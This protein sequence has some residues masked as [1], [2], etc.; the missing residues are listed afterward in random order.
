MLCPRCGAYAPEDEIV[1]HACGKLLEREK[2][3]EEEDLQSFYQGKHMRLRREAERQAAERARSERAADPG[4]SHSFRSPYQRAATEAPLYDDV[5]GVDPIT[6][7]SR[8]PTPLVPA[9]R[10]H[11]AIRLQ[12]QRKR[13][14]WAIVGVAV[15]LLMCGM[16]VGTYLYLDKTPGG[17]VLMARMGRD[18]N[19][20]ALWQV[21]AEFLDTG[22]LDTAI[23]YFLRA[24]EKD[25][26][27]PNV[28]GLLELGSA[29]EAAGRNEEAE[30]IYAHI[31]TDLVPSAPEAYRS[32]VRLLIA[33]DRQPEAADLL[34]LAYQ[35]TGVASFLSQRTDM[36]PSV[37][38]SSVIAGYYAEIK[39]VQLLQSQEYDVYYLLN[40][41]DN[42]ASDQLEAVLPDEGTLYTEPLKLGE[43][44]WTI[45]AVAVHEGLVSDPMTAVFQI[46]MPTPLQPDTTLAPGTYQQRQRV[47]LSPG[48]LTPEQLEKN[49]GYAASM[50]DETAMDITIYY[51]IDGS[52]PD[53]DSPIYTGEKILLPGGRVTLRAVAVNGYGK[54]GNVKEVGY[55]IEA[56]PWPKSVYAS[57]DGIADWKLGTT[58]RDV[59]FQR[60]GADAPSESTT[61]PHFAGECLRYQFSWG[62]ATFTRGKAGWVL[63]MVTLTNTEISGPRKTAVGMTESEVTAVFKDYGQVESPS[64]NRGLYD[65]LES[66]DR[67]KIYKQADGTKIIRYRTDT[68]EGYVWQLDYLVNQDG[69][70]TSIEWQ[71]EP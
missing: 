17:Q 23:D 56:K 50:K 27:S 36:L 4:A 71:Y 69:I 40:E 46:Y 52:M 45:K 1:C 7:T 26:D 62:T 38:Q 32:Q 42:P 58:T 37:P 18:A 14:N 54:A 8:V 55:K 43:G 19:A 5:G 16:A 48:S 29:Y 20:A 21:G 49:P 12:N 61:L 65:D 70:V 3:A 60:Y 30:A 44:E 66:S 51:T 34:K 24:Q 31:Y 6:S 13:V 2:D 35:N 39:T 59:F 25:G 53:A 63:A 11:R 41:L 10:S 67:G 47:G 57:S 68:A 9:G 15:I 33:E 22:D 28:S 64:G